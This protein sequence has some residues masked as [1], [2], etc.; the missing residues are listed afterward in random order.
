M[1]GGIITVNM[2]SNIDYEVVIPKEF[3]WISIPE[4]SKT[5][6]TKT[7]AVT[8]KIDENMSY[9][10]RDGIVYICNEDAGEEIKVIIHQTFAAV[11]KADNNTFE[12]AME[13]GTVTINMESNISYDVIIPEDCKWVTRSSAKTRAAKPSIVTLSVAENKS[14]NKN[15]ILGDGEASSIA[16]AIKNQGTIAYNNPSAIQYCIQGRQDRFR[17]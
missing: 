6:E 2:E 14:Y 9:G 16:I 17:C 8:L 3:N 15:Q 13:G 11:L 7:S 12:V 5:R 1:D 4:T 10:D